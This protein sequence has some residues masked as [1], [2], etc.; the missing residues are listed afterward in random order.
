MDYDRPTQAFLSRYPETILMEA[1][2]LRS[3]GAVKQIFGGEK[4][5][6]ARLEEGSD[7]YHVTLT[8]TPEHLGPV[9]VQISMNRDTANI[10]F[11][12][13]HADTR[14]ALAEAMPRLREL[15]ASSG[16]SLGQSG[17]SEQAP[18]ENF[19]PPASLAGS[20]T[21]GVDADT[22]IEKAAPAWRV[23]RPGLI[24]TYA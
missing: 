14:T 21:S 12:S 19:A 7:V 16:L 5:V 8:L 2:R 13:P 20:R 10:W 1:Q 11:G 22:V 17:V 3:E 24:D 23:W 9:E 18:R 15:L 4:F 6:R